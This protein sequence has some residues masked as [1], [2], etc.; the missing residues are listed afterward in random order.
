MEQGPDIYFTPEYGRLYEELEGGTFQEYVYEDENGRVACPFLLRPLAQYPGF[1]R[2]CD[3]ISPYGYGGPVVLRCKEGRRQ[4]L[5]EA[6]C[7]EFGAFCAKN[8]VVSFF[9]RFHPLLNNAADFRSAFD[10]VPFC[11]HT[12]AID[13][14]R[15]LFTEEFSPYVRRYYRKAVQELE[16]RIDRDLQTL[17]TF[18][19]IYLASMR[20]KHASAYYLFSEPYFENLRTR[21]AGHV[22]LYNAVSSGRI[23]ASLMLMKYG[24]FSHF[25]LMANSEEA[26]RN[27]ASLL[28]QAESMLQMKREGYRRNHL[29][30]GLSADPDD[31]LYRFKR[32]FSQ[33]PPCDFYVGKSIYDPEA[34]DALCRLRERQKGGLPAGNGFFPLYRA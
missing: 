27:H 10:E 17:D 15:E 21:L 13:L 31:S 26:Y 3:L 33:D 6:F 9:V 23:V 5:A 18:R 24:E 22:E 34:Y 30:G 25:H 19:A 29:G 20:E 12:V 28:L 14:S 16:V 4:A 7:R 1:E 11:R 2:Y 8:R 32:N